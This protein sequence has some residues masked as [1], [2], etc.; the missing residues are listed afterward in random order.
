MKLDQL[1]Y[2]PEIDGLRAI[3]V[4]SVIFYHA[5]LSLFGGGFV[6]VDI[7]FVIS[8]FLITNILINNLENGKFSF[9]NFYERRVRRILPALFLVLLVSTIFAWLSLIPYEFQLYSRALTS[10]I[11]FASNTKLGQ[12]NNYFDPI[13][14]LKP[15]TH[16]WSLAVEEQ[17]YIVFPILLIFL[18]KHQRNRILQ[19]LI[20]LSILSLAGA[21]VGSAIKPGENFY[22]TLT[23]S[24]ELLIGA[25][26]ALI[27]ARVSPNRYFA[28]L[29]FF[30]ITFAIFFYDSTTPTPSVFI[31][32]PTTGAAL[33]I[34][35]SK[36]DYSLT[37]FLAHKLPSFLGRI[38]YSAYLWHYPLF[39]F[40]RIIFGI[41]LSFFETT[42]LIF[43]T[44]ALAYLTWI[45]VEQPFRAGNRTIIR[46]RNSLFLLCGVLSF[47]FLMFGL[48]G[49]LLNGFEFR[50]P[51]EQRDSFLFQD[52]DSFKTSRSTSN[53][54]CARLLNSPP[55]SEEVCITNSVNP[56]VLI[57]GDS[58]AMS[59]Y[60]A[61][62]SKKYDIDAILIAAHGCPIYAN[63]TYRPTFETG[64]SNNCTA[65]AKRIIEMADTL[66]SIDTIIIF[67]EADE[68]NGVLSRFNL[69]GRQL[70]KADA[71][72]TAYSFVLSELSKLGKRI[73]LVSD[74]PSW[75]VDPKKCIQQLR[76][77]SVRHDGCQI[78][79]EKF[80]ENLKNYFVLVEEL[81]TNHPA[82]KFYDPT[83]I[84]CNRDGTC[85]I[86]D[87][88][89]LLY[90]DATHMSPLAAFKVLKAMESEGYI[91]H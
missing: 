81:K 48:T 3:A 28:I 30:F 89:K 55:L 18:W 82:V 58:K 88:K 50:L 22:L 60:S 14:E 91:K 7:F 16:T 53:D 17:F 4:T 39:S 36:A 70:T 74:N 52:D 54:S 69:D 46:N 19:I 26:S 56:K 34:L 84:L 76:L 24:W 62:Y 57:A 87:D 90:F 33:I 42:I 73:V 6:G 75:V 15:L 25:I 71:F 61:I 20:G 66:K 37:K 2:R 32:L 13:N 1:H 68:A 44:F 45:F 83:N 41:H 51:V 27:I 63:L 85:D 38:S 40:Y 23:R 65:I 21:E 29:G 31:L 12:E 5:G 80:R 59:L 64:F 72:R 79:V 11:L 8:G 10:V 49:Q 86:Q 77:S 47:L 78:N 35:F 9:L 67:N 43:C